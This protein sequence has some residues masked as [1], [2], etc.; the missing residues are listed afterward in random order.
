M[1]LAVVQGCGNPP[2]PLPSPAQSP[3]AA[4]AACNMALT[5][6]PYEGFHIGVPDGWELIRV[7]GTIFVTR[8]RTLTEV[9]AV[10]PA[11][12]T[13]GLSAAAYFQA[14][15]AALVRQL[16]SAGLTMTS[17][18]TSSG[19][20]L[21]AASLVIQAQQSS[22]TGQAHI[23]VVPF[24][25]AHSASI[26]ALIASWAPKVQ[27]STEGP[28]LAGIG[29]CYGPQ[30]G[31][32]FQVVKDAAFTY[33]IPLGWQTANESQ[34]S[35]E[36][37]KGTDAGA[38]Y[39]ALQALKPDTGVTTPRSLFDWATRQIGIQVAATL[40]SVS[41]PDQTTVTGSTLGEV[42]V[43]FTGTL[44]G[45][46]IHGFAFA[47]TTRPPSGTGLITSGV[48]RIAYATNASWTA[49]GGALVHIIGGI[50]HDFTQ[51]LQEWERL[52]QQAQAFGQQVQ[53]FDMAINGVDLVNDPT[54]GATFEAPYSSYNPSGPDGPGYYSAAGTKLTVQTP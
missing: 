18:V 40:A 25:T 8:D 23:E 22:M 50:Q 7:N 48:L 37:D 14:S 51:D 47:T 54:T 9:T 49:L 4:T 20:Q 36:I 2:P 39:T 24:Q 6:D 45:R 19:S 32:L 16:G 35:I 53:G 10:R 3:S 29:A 46:A 17:T 12:M 15:L 52:S 26:V 28:V 41:L 1:L 43:E 34:N 31:T 33:A 21:P 27:F 13:S 42:I 30:Q 44:K 38:S 11:L 5:A